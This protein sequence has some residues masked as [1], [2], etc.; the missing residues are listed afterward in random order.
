[1]SQLNTVDGRHSQQ[2]SIDSRRSWEGCR[3][4]WNNG[5]AVARGCE[6]RYS[7]R[8]QPNALNLRRVKIKWAIHLSRLASTLS[9]PLHHHVTSKPASI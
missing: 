3:R 8:E 6:V 9:L 4:C 7:A 1:M 5:F 2:S